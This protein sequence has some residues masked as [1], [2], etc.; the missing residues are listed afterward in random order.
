MDRGDSFCGAPRGE[1]AL[2]EGALQAGL[3]DVE[4]RGEGCGGHAACAAGDEV[5]PC[6][7]LFGR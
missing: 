1:L 4:G 7:A 6:F 5:R 2:V 3:E